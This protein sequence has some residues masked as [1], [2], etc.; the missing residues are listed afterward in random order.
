MLPAGQYGATVNHLSATAFDTGFDSADHD[1]PTLTT[2]TVA[3][4]DWI[5]DASGD[6]FQVKVAATDSVLGGVDLDATT[7]TTTASLNQMPV[8]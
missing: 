5:R 1:L 4:G 7:P 3:V 2:K 8:S 6:Y